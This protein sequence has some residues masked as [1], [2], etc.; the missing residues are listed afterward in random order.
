MVHS[1]TRRYADEKHGRL[2]G[3]DECDPSRADYLE[4]P[5][6]K[7]AWRAPRAPKDPN[8]PQGLATYFSAALPPNKWGVPRGLDLGEYRYAVK[9]MGQLLDECAVSPERIREMVDVYVKGSKVQ[10]ANSRVG[11]FWYLRRE[12]QI[13]TAPP[14]KK[15]YSDWFAVDEPDTS[16]VDRFAGWFA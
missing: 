4:E 10:T 9:V 5:V 11:M 6:Q 12:L 8:S 13:K 1:A 3:D 2:H 15:D 16:S 7:P 14:E